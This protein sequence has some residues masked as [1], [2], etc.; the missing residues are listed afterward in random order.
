MGLRVGEEDVDA[1]LRLSGVG[2]QKFFKFGMRCAYMADEV[3]IACPGP[4][5]RDNTAAPEHSIV[6][7]REEQLC[8]ALSEVNSGH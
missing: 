3:G 8:H 7:L 4:L 1:I 6:E 5:A 2:G